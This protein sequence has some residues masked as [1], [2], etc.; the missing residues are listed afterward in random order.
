MPARGK[1]PSHHGGLATGRGAPVPLVGLG[2]PW[3]VC[4]AHCGGDEGVT[5]RGSATTASGRSAG[6]GAL[7]ETSNRHSPAA[8][9]RSALRAPGHVW[10]RVGARGAGRLVTPAPP[11]GA[12]GQLAFPNATKCHD[13][14]TTTVHGRGVR[15]AGRACNKAISGGQLRAPPPRCPGGLLPNPAAENVAGRIELK[16]TTYPRGYLCC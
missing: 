7:P 4:V 3:V 5:V 12:P 1:P 14:A 10:K 6:G 16:A 11:V 9:Q 13:T 15:A 2:T 8:G